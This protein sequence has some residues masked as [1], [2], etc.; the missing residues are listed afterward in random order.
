VVAGGYGN[1]G[2]IKEMVNYYPFGKVWSL[3]YY[4][5][6]QTRYL[7]NGKEKQIV[8]DINYMD[9]GNRMYDDLLG[10]WFVQD[11]LQE[12]YPGLSSYA[13][14][15]NNPLRFIDPNGMDWYS[16]EEKYEKDGEERTRIKYEYVQGT[17]SDEDMEKGGYTH[18]GKTYLSD[19][20]YYSLGGAILDYDKSDMQQFG[21]V[22]NVMAADFFTITAVNAFKEGSDFWNKYSEYISTGSNAANTIANFM[23]AS[24][25]F[26]NLAKNIKWAGNAISLIQ[27]IKDVK[28]F[29]DGTMTTGRL[30]DA[31]VN[32]Y[33]WLGGGYGAGFAFMYSQY[34][35]AG[36][37]FIETVNK[38][39]TYLR[40]KFTNPATY[41]GW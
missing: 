24:G 22:A 40:N 9:Y 16:Y 7:F 10:R 11:L 6:A 38:G 17:M 33:S 2:G 13:Y 27:S 31:A 28:S 19:G 4:P 37:F 20:T 23:D 18:L 25:K 26:G 29:I 12:K 1:Y 35:N 36:D 3:D 39:E 34:K 5:A 8:G 41:L 21:M 30:I 14:C 32:V 15:G